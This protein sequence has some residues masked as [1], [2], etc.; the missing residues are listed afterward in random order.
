MQ[1]KV[2]GVK[3]SDEVC[4][5]KEI[6]QLPAVLQKYCEY[7]G[8]EKIPKYQ[9]VN[10]RFD[11][12][13]FIFDTKSEKVL[14]MDYDLWLFYDKIFRS[15][16]CRSS[17]CG[18]PFEGS[19][20]VTDDR[21]GGMQ[22]FLAKVLPL[23]N[24]CDAQGYKASLISWLAESAVINPSVFLS[25]YVSYEEIDDSHLKATVTYQGVSGSGIFTFLE[26]GA[27]SEF[28]SAERQVEEI[29]GQ[30]LRLGWKCY[31]E[32]YEERN[33]IRM[34][35]KIKSTKL[36]PDGKEL[37]YFASDNFTVDYLK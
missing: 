4:T 21:K 22:G 27:I 13:D 2:A 1:N 26:S 34:A 23:F 19:D 28:Y 37:V 16:F 9:V 3:A 15:A 5:R 31:C 29:D 17:I 18:I 8:L 24:V 11:K 20:Y 35:T 12:T 33:S 36:F 7:I 32:Q 14:K 30:K 6:E 10:V 25:P